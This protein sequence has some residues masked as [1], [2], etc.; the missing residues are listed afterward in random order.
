MRRFR[1]AERLDAL[2]RRKCHAVPRGGMKERDRRLRTLEQGRP[3]HMH[4]AI[5]IQSHRRAVIW[6]A[7]NH[8][9]IFA[10]TYERRE[11]LT[12]VVRHREGDVSEATGID[13]PEGDVDRPVAA[14]RHGRLAAPAYVRGQPRFSIPSTI[15]TSRREHE[16]HR[17]VVPSGVRMRRRAGIAPTIE[18]HRTSDAI[19]TD[20]Y[21]LEPP[22]AGDRLIADRGGRQKSPTA[23]DG[24]GRP[25]AEMPSAIGGPR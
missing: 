13:I 15:R 24:A 20:G 6:A 19:R 22:F 10:D 14:G 1:R 9:M 11:C 7:V 17:V 18:P 2:S 4:D 21:R 25:E 16:V 3:H 23:I 12:A 8:P 5:V